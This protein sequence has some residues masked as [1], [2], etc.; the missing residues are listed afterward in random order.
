[1]SNRNYSLDKTSKQGHVVVKRVADEE[2]GYAILT[3]ELHGNEVFKAHYGQRWLSIDT[4]G[5]YTSATRDVINTALK[6]LRPDMR[7]YKSAHIWRLAFANGEE[8]I[9]LETAIGK[10]YGF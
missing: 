6:E 10:K 1:M 3:V 2:T 7:V 5:W 4:C 9:C 8:E